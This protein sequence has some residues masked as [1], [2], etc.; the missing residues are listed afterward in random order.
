L[1]TDGRLVEAGSA[2]KRDAERA[3]LAMASSG[4]AMTGTGAEMRM[5]R[6]KALEMLKPNG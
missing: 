1:S 5:L 4:V 6:V 2:R 3:A